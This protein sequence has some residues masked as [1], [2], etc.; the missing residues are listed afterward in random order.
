MKAAEGFTAA[1]FVLAMTIAAIIAVAAGGVSMVLSQA[2]QHQDD[3]RQSVQSAAGVMREMR[4]LV[5]KAQLITGAWGDR[6]GIW[7]DNNNSWTIQLS[8]LVLIRYDAVNRQ[9]LET[10]LAFPSSWTPAQIAA[11]DTTLSRAVAESSAQVL[12]RLTADP[13]VQ[14]TV[15]A[16]DVSAFSVVGKQTLSNN[17]VVEVTLT[18]GT[19]S[20]QVAVRSAMALR[21]NLIG[22]V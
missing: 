19:G 8:E 7:I 1:E 18:V 15:L 6:A 20:K 12:S 9:V 13:Y 17:K 21:A 11:A 4:T 2:Y 5:N 14:T 16:E 10:K 22:K 3:Y